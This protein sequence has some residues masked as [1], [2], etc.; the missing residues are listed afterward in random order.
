MRAW[1]RA[2]LLTEA[3]TITVANERPAMTPLRKRK[4]SGLGGV[5]G[6]NWDTT[7]PRFGDLLLKTAVLDGIA[8]PQ[9]SAEDGNRAPP[10]AQRLGVGRG[11][12]PH[13]QA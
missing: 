10:A 1:I 8:V 13:G 5:S 9:A 2:P 4:F 6:Q 12:D 11:I 7:A 3:S